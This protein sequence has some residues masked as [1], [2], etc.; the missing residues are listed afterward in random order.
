[1][2][3]LP[4]PSRISGG[5]EPSGGSGCSAL[6]LAMQPAIFYHSHLACFDVAVMSMWLVTTYAYFRSV[7]SKSV[8]WAVLTG[9]LYGLELNTKHNAWLLPPALIVHFVLT[10]GRRGL[11]RDLATGRT[12]LPLALGTM[13]TLGPLVFY[14]TW[15]WLWFDTGKRLVEYVTFHVNHEYYNMEFWA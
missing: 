5:S 6:L 9:L 3:V 1:L 11:L 14:A 7:E 4:L 12:R 8:S 2:P 10:R 13:A 15:P